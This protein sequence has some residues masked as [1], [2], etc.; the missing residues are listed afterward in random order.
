MKNILNVEIKSR[1]KSLYEIE[2]TL[3]NLG[4]DF[5]GVDHQIDTYFDARKGRLKLRHGNIENSLIFYDRSNSAKSRESHILLEKL[6]TESNLLG[7]LSESIGIKIVVDKKRKIFFIE[8]VKFH[9]DE[10]E[11]LGHFVEI[12]AICI[13]GSKNIEELKVQ[14]DHYISV[15]KLKEKDFVELSYSDMVNENFHSKMNREAC[16]FL[17]SLKPSLISTNIDFEGL[18]LDHLCYRVTS[19]EEYLWFFENFKNIGK[20]LVESSVGGR[21]IATFKLQAPIVWND[22]KIDVIELPEPKSVN[23]YA[24]GFEHA[25][26]VISDDFQ[27]FMKKYSHLDFELDAIS[28]KINPDIRLSFD[29]GESIKFHHQSLESVIEYEKSMD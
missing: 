7:I 24:T 18:N 16:K 17:E 29:T 27:I 4:A 9:V 23:K 6:G 3:L 19:K 26:F 25:E 10:V 28:K 12:E 13:D 5:K 15:L 21:Q 11:N 8:N 20:L 14:C 22:L 1:C 2:Q